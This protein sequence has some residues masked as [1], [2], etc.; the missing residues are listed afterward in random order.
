MFKLCRNNEHWASL[1]SKAFMGWRLYL[2]SRLQ[3]EIVVSKRR[4]R[5]WFGAINILIHFR[6]HDKIANN[7]ATALGVSTVVA[8]VQFAST[9]SERALWTTTRCLDEVW[10]LRDNWERLDAANPRNDDSLTIGTRGKCAI[11]LSFKPEARDTAPTPIPAN[12]FLN[13]HELLNFQFSLSM[14]LILFFSLI[15]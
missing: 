7:I 15:H 9:Q 12:S 3:V 11:R 13:N 4:A 5:A 14:I 10:A 8:I 1:L 6:K 2:S